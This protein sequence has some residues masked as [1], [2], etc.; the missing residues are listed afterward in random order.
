[1][2]FA[3]GKRGVST[4]AA[5][6]PSAARGSRACGR[7]TRM[8]SVSVSDC[9]AK[10]HTHTHAGSPSPSR[11]RERHE[12]VRG[13]LTCF[14]RQRVGTL[15]SKGA[16]MRNDVGNAMTCH[17]SSCPSPETAASL[18]KPSV[19]SRLSWSRQVAAA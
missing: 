6:G 17:P 16:G 8:H 15:W 10:G 11:D 12:Q 1:M 4:A 3:C 18:P 7:K 19:G 9:A 14:V 2:R 5:A 13:K